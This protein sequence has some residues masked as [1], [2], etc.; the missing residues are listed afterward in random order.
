MSVKHYGDWR[1]GTSLFAFLWN[2][3]ETTSGKLSIVFMIAAL[4]VEIMRHWK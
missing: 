2:V 4:I 1:D 3:F